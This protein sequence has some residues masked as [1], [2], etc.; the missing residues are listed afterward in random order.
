MN[1]YQKAPVPTIKPL[2]EVAKQHQPSRVVYP[3]GIP[4]FDEAL[5]GGVRDGELIVV[6]GKTGEGKSLLC[7][8]LTFNFSKQQIP[9]LWFSYEMSSFYLMQRFQKHS[10]I[11]PHFLVYVPTDLNQNTIQFLEDKIKEAKKEYNCK[12]VFIDHLHFLVPLQQ[13]GNTSLMIG[14]IMRKL[15]LL[16]LKLNVI[17]FLI[18]HTKKVYQDESLSLSSIRDSSL[19]SQEAD[20]V[21]LIERLRESSKGKLD[22]EDSG[23]TNESKVTLAKNRRTGQLLF[24]K[25]DYENGIL[26][27]ETFTLPPDPDSGFEDDNPMLSP[28]N[29]T[30][31]YEN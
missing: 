2:E 3:L 20:Y 24:L 15:K 30:K 17:I 28:Y 13:V 9:S 12:V 6:S 16:A 8:S 19:I 29:F 22:I 10:P 31:H 21:F 7:Q 5:D 26:V 1:T 23:W 4:A 27:P 14:G 25:F 11:P 18:A